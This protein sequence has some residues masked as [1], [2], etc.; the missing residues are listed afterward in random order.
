MGHVV[1]MQLKCKHSHV[2]CAGIDRELC[3]ITISST[4]N[5]GQADKIMVSVHLPTHTLTGLAVSLR[6]SG[7]FI[8][9]ELILDAA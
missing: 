6:A 9:V 2:I 7:P 8:S 5:D 1:S 3:T 4:N